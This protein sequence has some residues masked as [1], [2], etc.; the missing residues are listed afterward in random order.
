MIDRDD[1]MGTRRGEADLQDLM[2]AEPRVQGDAAAAKAVG[3]D[4]RCHLAVE[5]CLLQ[6]LD[7]DVALPGAIGVLAPVLDRAAAANAKMRAER[8][9]ARFACG[10]DREQAPAVRMAVHLGYFDRLA[11][12]CVGH[13]NCLAI[14]GQRDA[15]AAVT[16]MVDFKI[17][18][19]GARR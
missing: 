2:R 1:V 7:D 11:G 9:D 8:R 10:L 6:R 3:V 19:H 4:Q 5:P 14:G 16:D 15:V 13:L 12:E 18:N 17:F